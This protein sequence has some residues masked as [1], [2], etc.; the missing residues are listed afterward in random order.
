MLQY[1]F[2]LK[3]LVIVPIALV[4]DLFYACVTLLF[5]CCTYIDQ[6]VGEY[7]DQAMTKG[8]VPDL[9]RRK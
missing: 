3:L 1:L 6:S 8:S 4:W 5:R 9:F 2:Y 7:I